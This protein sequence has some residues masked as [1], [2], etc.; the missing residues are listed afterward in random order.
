MGLAVADVLSDMPLKVHV[1]DARREWV[2]RVPQHPAI[3][4]HGTDP[5]RYASSFDWSPN[6]A[7]CVFTYDHDLDF[8][9]TFQLLHRDLG[10]LGL[11]GSEHKAR[12]MRARAAD[13]DPPRRDEVLARWDETVDCPMG[14]KLASKNPK[15]IAVSIVVRLLR[16]WALPQLDSKQRARELMRSLD[17]GED[18]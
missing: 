1:I 13:R 11:I 9:L 17:R 10:Y 8:E 4:S 16:S 14:E 5:L 6:D 3:T 12:V 7:V 2:D 18:A 15:V